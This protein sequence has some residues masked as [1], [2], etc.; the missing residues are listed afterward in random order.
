[1][2]RIKEKK[3]EQETGSVGCVDVAGRRGTMRKKGKQ[4]PSGHTKA[5]RT[6]RVALCSLGDCLKLICFFKRPQAVYDFL[7]P[8]YSIAM[9]NY[10]RRPKT[11]KSKFEI[12]IQPQEGTGSSSTA[13]KQQKQTTQEHN[14]PQQHGV[15]VITPNGKVRTYVSRALEILTEA[16]TPVEGTGSKNSDAKEIG[17]SSATQVCDIDFFYQL[18]ISARERKYRAQCN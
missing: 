5:T 9:E 12:D 18:V 3:S 2:E 11:S 14:R 1:M 16:D 15:M 17:S 13:K 7:Q 6:S 4:R 10:H 8:T